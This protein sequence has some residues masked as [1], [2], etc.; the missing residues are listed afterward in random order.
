MKLSSVFSFPRAAAGVS[1]AE[2]IPRSNT[3]AGDRGIND[4]RGSILFEAY[5]SEGRGKG[6]VFVLR[7]NSQGLISRKTFFFPS[8]HRTY[9]KVRQRASSS[10]QEENSLY[11][12][13]PYEKVPR[14]LLCQAYEIHQAHCMVSTLVFSVGRLAD[15]PQHFCCGL[16]RTG[17]PERSL[18]VLAQAGREIG[19]SARHSSSRRFPGP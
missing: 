11:P 14:R 18:L 10:S 16:G 2:C 1:A 19:E 9:Q 3:S 15:L 12:Y 17:Q 13:Y 8:S 4:W 7:S 6:N 5:P